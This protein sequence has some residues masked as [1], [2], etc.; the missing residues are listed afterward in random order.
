[1]AAGTL[2]GHDQRREQFCQ[3][4]QTGVKKKE[5]KETIYYTDWSVWPEEAEKRTPEE[6][7]NESLHRFTE[8]ALGRSRRARCFA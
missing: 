8:I 6:T 2:S 4:H 5:K 7:P 3:W 1:M